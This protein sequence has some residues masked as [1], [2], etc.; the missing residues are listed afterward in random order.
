[1]IYDIRHRTTY[2]YDE[3]VAI[4]HHLA[5]FAPRHMPSQECLE[6]DVTIEPIPADRSLRTD[7]FG[8]SAVFFAMRAP[9][10]RLTVTSHSKV[11]IKPIMLPS[12][13]QTPPWE[14]IHAACRADSLTDAAAA[15]EYC[16]ASSQV[17]VNE[18]LA[19]YAAQSFTPGRLMLDAALHLNGRIF[20]EFTFDPK[21]TDVATPV[22]EAFKKRRGVCQDFAHI[23]IACVRSLGLPA[24]YVSGYLETLPPPGRP[25]L[26]G[27][28]ASHAWVS[29]WCGSQVGW[30]D[31]D[32]TNNCIPGARHIT[33]AYGR[34]FHDVSPLRGIVLG[35]GS[36]ELTVAVDVNPLPSE[37]TEV[38]TQVE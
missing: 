12:S 26:V 20:N 5:R 17:P 34:D 32:P 21:A 14:T 13:E 24:R 30:V 11:K 33:V 36:H 38:A 37:D 19:S 6:H 31:F 7:Y 18:E 3:P 35:Q 2:V 4:S 10:R 16:F 28:D 27:A 15:G 9:H 23:F 1:M 25:K 8:N 22:D 29:I